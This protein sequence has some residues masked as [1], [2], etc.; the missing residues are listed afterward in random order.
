MKILIVLSHLMNKDGSLKAE[1]IARADKAIEIFHKYKINLVLTIGWPYRKDTHIPIA[2]AFKKYFLSKGIHEDCIKSDINSR[3]TV[4]D[5]IFS[6]INVVDQYNISNIY[7]V[8]S[9]YHVIRT[10][11][12]FETV[13][14]RNIEVIGCPCSDDKDII[15]NEESSLK[16]FKETFLNTDF[17]SNNSII[18]TLQMNHPFY[19]G[20]VHKSMESNFLPL[21]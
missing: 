20:K 8:T 19:N 3:D 6:K 11:Y 4:G 16:A 14:S 12:I 9:D 2:L 17:N 1:S 18:K 15:K 21:L 5:A 10:K 7:V 13:M